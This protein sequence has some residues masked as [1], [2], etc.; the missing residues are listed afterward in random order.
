L[1]RGEA[2]QEL[3]ADYFDQ[4]NKE[5]KVSYLTRQLE[6]LTGA[7]VQITFSTVAA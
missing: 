3:G 5:A 7:T 2:Y 1:S 4:R 6:K